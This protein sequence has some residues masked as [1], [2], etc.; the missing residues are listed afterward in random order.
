MISGFLG[1]LICLE[2]AVAARDRWPYLLA[3]FAGLGSLLLLLGLG[4]RVGIMLI[5]LSSGGLVLLFLL[6]MRRHPALHTGVMALGALLWLIGNLMWLAGRPLH[7]V[8]WWWA[9]FLILTIAGERLELSRVLRHTDSVI[10]LFLGATAVFLIGLTLTRFNYDWG[11]RLTGLGMLLIALWLLR[12]DLAR[13]NIGK[14]GLTGYIAACL[15]SGYL[16]LIVAGLLA[17]WYG[18]VSAGPIYDAI[19]HTIFL[20]FVFGMIFGHAP[21]IFPAVLGRP[22]PYRPSFYL[23]LIL[24]QVTLILRL[25]GDLFTWHIARQWGGLLNALVLLVFLANMIYSL[26]LGSRQTAEQQGGGT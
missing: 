16:W 2:R 6:H 11:V 19:L 14:E 7:L 3:V 22:L 4:D 17:M 18:A 26:L 10:R 9:G 20:G 24:L 23:H 15:F 8:V 1:T 12:Y 21:I 13:Y 25:A 5:A